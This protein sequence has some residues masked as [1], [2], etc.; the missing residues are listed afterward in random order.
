M[1]FLNRIKAGF[2]SK[3]K[4]ELGRIVQPI[5]SDRLLG[6]YSGAMKPETLAT[7]H[8][9]ADTGDIERAMRLYADIISKDLHLASVL[10]TRRGAVTGCPWEIVPAA[11][12]AQ[13]RKDADLVR[14]VLENIPDFKNMIIALMEA[15][16][17][18]F[19]NPEIMWATD[20]RWI[21]VESV[22]EVMQHR[23]IFRGPDW[24][25]LKFPRLLM[26]E[27]DYVGVEIPPEKFLFHRF[28]PRGGYV[29]RSGL[30][31]G[32]AWWNLFQSYS[33]KDWMAFM[34]R[35][36]QGFILG[37]YDSAASPGDRDVLQD[38]VRNM[39]TEL[40]AMISK[41]TEIEIHEFKGTSTIN[42]FLDFNEF[43]DAY[44]SKRVLGQTL[45]TQEGESG[46]YALGKVQNEVRQDILEYDCTSV[47]NTVQRGLVVPIVE[48][49]HGPRDKYPKFQIRFEPPEDLK[50]LAERDK[51]LVVDMGVPVPLSYVRD[52]YGIPEPEGDEPVLGGIAK[53]EEQPEDQTALDSEE[54]AEF[55]A[56]GGELGGLGS[57]VQSL[58]VEL[59][60]DVIE[61]ILSNV[62]REIRAFDGGLLD[63]V[64]GR[65]KGEIDGLV[66][67]QRSIA[68]ATGALEQFFSSDRFIDPDSGE[69]TMQPRA[70]AELYVRNE[71]KQVYR[72]AAL[73]SA[74]QA[75]P[76][77]QLYAFSRGPRDERT[78]DDSHEIEALTNWEY[79]GTPMPVEQYWAHSV[80]QRAHR[81][82]DRGRDV[83][84]PIWRFPEEVQRMIRGRHG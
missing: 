5:N 47:M 84:W 31:R 2:A 73:E 40:A 25:L 29:A 44:K 48:Y 20:G 81:P 36:G 30:M 60:D 58:S 74:K 49:N 80:V 13:G 75:Y 41:T 7:I 28:Q 32:L 82:N 72:D 54:R 76:D 67:G 53:P 22:D 70:R 43:A 62:G 33:L 37:R 12:D 35:F 77:Q 83:I 27:G 24:M 79:G 68:D 52:T 55:Q 4:P 11:D 46:S 39:A 63:L 1:K 57:L 38:A 65:V 51:V 14:E 50:A 9:T 45:T 3:E 64:R 61:K 66:R 42:M 10:D 15:V 34:E 18:G 8:Y 56:E 16:P 26:K 23:F 59:G 78:A 69:Y 21:Y 71:L 17:Y 6:S 19:A